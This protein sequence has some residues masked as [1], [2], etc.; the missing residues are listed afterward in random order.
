MKG[1][2]IIWSFIFLFQ[3]VGLTFNDVVQLDEF[4]EHTKFHNKHYGDTIF[5]FISKHYGELKSDHHKEHQEEKSKHEQLPFQNNIYLSSIGALSLV[6]PHKL[7]LI[8]TDFIDF[9]SHNFIYK[10]SSSSLYSEGHFQP[11]RYI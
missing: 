1:T 6:T 2:S 8:T 3:S 10:E 9:K 5:V 7:E 11:P 4:I